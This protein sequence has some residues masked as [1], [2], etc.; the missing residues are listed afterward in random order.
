MEIMI[1]ALG[2]GYYDDGDTQ[3]KLEYK[4]IE[5]LTQLGQLPLKWSLNKGI[6]YLCKLSKEI[7]VNGSYKSSVV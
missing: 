1:E 2:E 5:R 3:G 4:E 7:P 6:F